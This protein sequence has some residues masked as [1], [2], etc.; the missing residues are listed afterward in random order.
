MNAKLV[1]SYKGKKTWL[2]NGKLV[3]TFNEFRECVKCGRSLKS[4]RSKLLGMG[5][6]CR[7]AVRKSAKIILIFPKPEIQ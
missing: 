6:G 1:G 3:T 2:F 7:C 5:S 4:D